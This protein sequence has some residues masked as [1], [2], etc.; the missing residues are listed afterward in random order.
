MT[1][2]VA[3][4]V[5]AL[6]IAIF[7]VPTL[8]QSTATVLARASGSASDYP[9]PSS[10]GYWVIF[11]KQISRGDGS[12]AQIF[13][14]TNLPEG[15]IYRTGN[16]VFGSVA[17]EAL[18][19]MYGC[20]ESVR[21]GL[22]GLSA[23][24]DSCNVSISGGER[25]AG[26]SVTVTITPIVEDPAPTAPTEAGDRPVPQPNNVLAILG[27]H[28]ERLAGDQAKDLPD[29]SGKELVATAMYDWP[30]PQCGG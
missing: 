14:E 8:R 3:F 12:S 6:A 1:I 2:A 21:N 23:G 11:P 20:C 30:E 29:G 5:F 17:G 15:T 4:A 18:T 25:S 16:T 28:F 26:F 22:I 19:S 10:S 9:P 7:A 13:A 24:N 27:D